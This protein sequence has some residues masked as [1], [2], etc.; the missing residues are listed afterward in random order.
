[1]LALLKGKQKRV[2]ED[3]NFIKFLFNDARMS[4]IW[5]V[6]RV[7]LGY[8]WIN[9][10]L[11]KISEPGWV[12]TGASLK[13]FWTSAIAIPESGRPAITFDWYRSFLQFLLDNEAYVWFAK[14]I[15]YGEFLVGVA[16]I[17]GAFV[18]V[19]AFCGA[20]M[21]FNFMLAGSASTNPVLFLM[22]ILLLF[23]WKVAGFIGADY[24]L[25]NLIGTPW[26]WN[27]FKEDVPEQQ[28]VAVAAGD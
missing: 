19:A 8:Q 20:L 16:L 2:I 7:W 3:P 14:L 12:E 27:K 1:M 17:I 9:A 21:N 10:A 24:V 15:A 5:L 25:L 28:Y 22:A 18:G 4:I 13:G 26:G 11:H 6:I 23:A